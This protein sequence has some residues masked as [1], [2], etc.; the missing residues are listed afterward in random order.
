MATKNTQGKTRK[1]TEPYEVWTAPGWEWRV[2][3]K[4][5]GPEAEAKNEYARWFLGTKSPYTYGDHE[6]GDGYVKDVKDYA[7]KVFDETV[8]GPFADWAKSL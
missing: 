1:V 5:Q 6:L 7:T 8:D 2:L 4:Y 3:K